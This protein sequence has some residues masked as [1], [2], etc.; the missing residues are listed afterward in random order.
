[1]RGFLSHLYL[2]PSCHRCKTKEFNSRADFTLA[3]YWGIDSKFPEFNDNK[4]ISLVII[5]TQ[6]GQMLFDKLSDKMDILQSDIEHALATNPSIVKSSLPNKRR[7]KF[8]A[9]INNNSLEAT[10]NNCIRATF[11]GKV[12]MALD[13]F[14][15]GKK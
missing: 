8:F 9:D 2:R 4:G 15:R 12:K 1:M 5:N 14:I 7:G 10:I 11:L 3:D 13:K 6:K